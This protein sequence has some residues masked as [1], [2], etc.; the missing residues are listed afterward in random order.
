[1]DLAIPI[2]R[3]TMWLKYVV[4]VNGTE[5]ILKGETNP[6]LDS[7]SQSKIECDVNV[8]RD[9]QLGKIR[10]CVKK[11]LKH[12]FCFFHQELGVGQNLDLNSFNIHIPHLTS[13]HLR[14]ILQVNRDVNWLNKS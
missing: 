3:L 6:R 9:L 14:N 8:A 4:T 5:A 10:F 12:I 2:S 11:L 7:D 1:M 13:S